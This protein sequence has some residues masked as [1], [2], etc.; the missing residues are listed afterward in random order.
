MEL[1]VPKQFVEIDGK[2]LFAFALQTFVQHPR[3]DKIALVIPPSYRDYVLNYL[4]SAQP[5]KYSDCKSNFSKVTLVDGADTRHRSI[6]NGVKFLEELRE[7]NEEG[8]ENMCSATPDYDSR[9]RK[10]RKSRHLNG[11]KEDG[12]KIEE[13]DDGFDVNTDGVERPNSSPEEV[14]RLPS[15]DLS[16]DEVVVIHDAARPFLDLPTLNAVIDAAVEHGAAGVVRPLVSTVIKPDRD[17]FLQETLVRA[18]YRAS[19]MPQAFSLPLIGGAYSR[20]SETDLDFGTECL[21]I[22]RKYGGVRAKL[23]EGGEH[24]WKVTYAK[25]LDA[26]RN[27]LKANESMSS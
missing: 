19:E 18:N 16:G 22:A 5:E 1:P 13:C 9:F 24:L 10:R 21:E 2:P 7:R 12:A 27:K 20:C 14:S 23:V 11:T 8:T 4:E 6:W 17:G 25:D 15:C 3:I 26:V